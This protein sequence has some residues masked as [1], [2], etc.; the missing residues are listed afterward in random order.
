MTSLSFLQEHAPKILSGEKQHTIRAQRKKP[1]KPGEPLELFTG[2]R[3]SN[4]V[5][6]MHTHCTMVQPISIYSLCSMSDFLQGKC[7]ADD[8]VVELNGGK[9]LQHEVYSLALEDGFTS[10]DRFFHFF[11][12]NDRWTERGNIGQLIHWAFPPSR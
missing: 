2:L 10:I 12:T 8:L 6:L 11:L 9:L 7:G 1:I 4:V 5:G 3:T